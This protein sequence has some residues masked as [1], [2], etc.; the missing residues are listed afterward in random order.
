MFKQSRSLAGRIKG[1]RHA[2]LLNDFKLAQR[3]RMALI[4]TMRH[5]DEP[6]RDE[7]ARLVN[8]SG[9]WV[10]N[11]GD[12]HKSKREI[13]KLARDIVPELSARSHEERLPHG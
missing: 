3:L 4:A 6:T 7:V 11:V 10:R 13:E 1:L 8:V 5:L 12:R 9:M 2:V